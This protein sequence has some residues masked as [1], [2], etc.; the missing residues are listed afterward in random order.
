M[1]A[2]LELRAVHALVA[3]EPS[4]IRQSRTYQGRGRRG[5]LI[6]LERGVLGNP[7]RLAV[8]R[9]YAGCRHASLRLTTKLTSIQRVNS[10]AAR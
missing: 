6:L 4:S 5:E 10:L 8:T 2:R 1:Q 7:D 3:A 9:V